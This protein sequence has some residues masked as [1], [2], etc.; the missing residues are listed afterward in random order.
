MSK[1]DLSAGIDLLRGK[2]S[3]QGRPDAN[4]VMRIKSYRDDKGRRDHGGTAQDLSRL[5][6]PV[7]P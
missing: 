2:V 3:G 5:R 1:A 4:M 6:R 7:P